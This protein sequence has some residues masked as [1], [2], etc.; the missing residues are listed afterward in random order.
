MTS[1]PPDAEPAGGQYVPHP[2]DLTSEEQRLRAARDGVPWRFW[3]PYLSERQWGTVREDYSDNG[4][5]WSYFSHDQA[6]SRAYRW[7]E[8]GLAGQCDEHQRLCFALAL[9]NEHDPILKERLFGLTNSEGNHGEDVKEYYFFVD[10][11]PTHSFQRWLYKYPQA[12][13]PYEDLVAT[14]RSRSRH[15]AEYE[16][17]DTGIF[18][19][20]RYFDVEVTYAK[21]DTGDLVC[22]ITVHNRGPDDAPIHLLPTLW[23]RNT[24]TFPPHTPRPT[25]T[26]V[27]PGVVRAEHDAI[28]TWHLHAPDEAAL[29][30]CENESNAARLWGAADSPP[31][32]KDGIADHVLHGSPT[33]NPDGTGTKVAAHVRL[34]VPAGGS[35]ETWLR[36][37][38]GEPRE[39]PFA[40][41]PAVVA[42]RQADADEFYAAITPE[43]VGDDAGAVMRQALAGML[44]SKQSYYF[45]LDVWLQ[46]HRAHPLRHPERFDTRNAAWFHMLNH[47]VI[48]MPDT[49]EYPWYAAWD[50]AFHCLP[51]AMVDPD[52]ATSQLDLMLSQ[53]YLHPSGQMPAYE[54]N[55]GDVNPP[56]HAFATLFMHSVAGHMGAVDMPFLRQSF[57]RLLLNF[58]WWVNRKDPSGKNVFEGGFLGLDNIGVF[59][60]SAPLPN[61]GRLEQADGTGWMA[62]FSQNMLELAI[63]LVEDDPDYADFVLKFIEHFY[64][65][66]AAIDPVGNNPD[67]MWDDD[68]GFFYDVLRH[69]D[70]T[71]ERLKVRSLVGLLP[72][73]ATTVVSPELFDRHPEIL[74]RI[75]GFLH[76]NRDLHRQRRRPVRAGRARPPPAVRRQRGQAAPHPR[77]DARRG[78]L[79]RPARDPLDL[80]DPPQRAL[81]DR[82]RRRDPPRR[83]RTGGVDDRDV[84][85]QLELAR[86][87]VVPR[88]RAHHPRPAAALPLLRRRLHDRVPDGVRQRD[89]A[90]RGRQGDLRPARRDVPARRRRP[91]P[92][93]RRHGEV[94]GR[95]AL[96][97]PDPVPRVLPRRRRCRPRGVAPDR[98]D[99]PRG[100]ADPDVRPPHAAGRA[101]AGGPSAGQALPPRDRR[102]DGQG[103]DRPGGSGRPSVILPA[104]PVV[105]EINTWVWLG[106]LSAAAGEPV[107]LGDVPADVWDAVA[108]PGIDVVWLMGVWQRS[109]AGAAIAREH[110]AMAAAQREALPDVTADD[111]VGSAYCIRD[112]VVDEHLG[113]DAGLA[114]ARAELA[115]RGVAL[116]L[117]FVPNHVAPD[118]PWA[119]AHP[120]RF[121]R[122]TADDLAAD[123]ASFLAVGDAVIARG[124]DP[125]FPAWPEVLQLD[126]SRPDV[127][128]AA[129]DDRAVDRRAVR[130]R[131]LR[132]GDARAR[133]HLRAHV[134]R[135]GAAAAPVS[136]RVLERANGRLLADGHRGGAGTAPR[137]RVLGRGLLGPRTAPRRAGFRRLLRQ[138][139]L[140]PARAP[141]ARVR[142]SASTSAADP[143]YQV[144]TVRFVENHDEPRRGLGVRRGGR[145]RPLPSS[146]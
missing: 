44:W 64:W 18:D 144:H 22:R 36:L 39:A 49:W 126:A 125:Y 95:P 16:L 38:E 94:P 124:R 116:V 70:G 139:P 100:A 145:A 96:A 108:G 89:D 131:A 127:R 92:G 91:A 32:P 7:G 54:W 35:T 140:R 17:L 65:I 132:H 107:T 47:D 60:R 12:A 119:L 137:L 43:S 24:W 82:R 122:G 120:E 133:R 73:C 106:D 87:G 84:R 21:A 29:L 123:P 63:E 80:A 1:A 46:E 102:G 136:R 69:P 55:F 25:L 31:F 58:T 56:V 76:R 59:D 121:V 2:M 30:F 112:Y 19:D 90:L 98:L 15:E 113:G 85:R 88:Q 67:E 37:V 93:V 138:A 5:A 128:A 97:R 20:D 8:D 71:G 57:T 118:H 117:D 62:L 135:S 86:A 77:P 130:R 14:N 50:L 101:R 68:D 83:V 74:R 79:P 66:A 23:F 40:D 72:L 4:D 42:A 11:L 105:H 110:P 45:D 13:Y 146:P 114:A 6:R 61:G 34:V 33:V 48:S 26:Q 104:N 3:G 103:R 9:W 53:V 78:P 141:G 41:A 10:N 142:R 129:A 143:A 81:R 27:A 52:F 109:P 134:G 28:G 51:L 111:V 99:R 115:A 75:G